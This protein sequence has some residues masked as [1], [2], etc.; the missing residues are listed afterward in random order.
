[1]DENRRGLDS[2][3]DANRDP[4]TGEPGSHP[5]GTGVGAAGGAAT[6]AAIGGAV[7][8]PVGAAVG[9]VAGA[10]AGGAAGHAVS[11]G[12]D[13]TVQD[14]Y[15]RKTYTTRPYYHA[16]WTYEEYD[17]AYRYGWESASSPEYRNRKF[18]EAESDLERGWEKFK[19]KSRRVWSE[20]REATRDAWNRVRGH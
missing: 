12:L 14:A 18:D 15:W 7:G 2:T 20:I 1:M 13:P 10:V 8:G 19:G 9:G 5:I 3:P 17:L 4:L 16:G 6:G 11:E